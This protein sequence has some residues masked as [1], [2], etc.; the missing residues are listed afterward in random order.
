V[1][2]FHRTLM[3][4]FIAAPLCSFVRLRTVTI[5]KMPASHAEDFFR[6]GA[7]SLRTTPH[8]DDYEKA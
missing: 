6:T 1:A 8:G 2:C 3:I 4:P 5:T 7:V